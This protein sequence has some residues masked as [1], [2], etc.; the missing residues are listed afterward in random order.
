M[1]VSR[2]VSFFAPVR[3]SPLCRS[4]AMMALILD[5]ELLRRLVSRYEVPVPVDLV[6]GVGLDGLELKLVLV[7]EVGSRGGGIESCLMLLLSMLSP[8]GCEMLFFEAL[9]FQDRLNLRLRELM[10]EGVGGSSGLERCGGDFSTAFV[11]DL[12]A[13]GPEG[14]CTGKS[15]VVSKGRVRSPPVFD[16]FMNVDSIPPLGSEV[17]KNGDM[18]DR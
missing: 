8:F 12:C 14:L 4:C 5:V 2:T 15:T 9:R 16:L 3:L 6:E 10:D 13:R 11:L 18:P 7:A 1:T 17:D